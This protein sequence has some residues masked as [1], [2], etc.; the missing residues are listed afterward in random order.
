MTPPAKTGS[1][2]G[3]LVLLGRIKAAQGL[4]GEVRV[5]SFTELPENIAAYGPLTDGRGRAFTIENLRVIKENVL[6]ASLSGVSSRDAA[7]AL[8][9]T[10]LFVEKSRLPETAEDEWYHEDLVGLRAEDE[11][12]VVIGEVVAV[13]NHGAGD[14]LEIRL[15]D[16][17][18]TILVPFSQQAVPTVD[19]ARRRVVVVPPVFEEP[20]AGVVPD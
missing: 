20:D 15:S 3:D 14:L 1:P 11:A 7:E 8:K 6:A 2:R 9:G 16:S 5:V 12:G 18:R 13:H 10:E 4:R 17:R 19:I